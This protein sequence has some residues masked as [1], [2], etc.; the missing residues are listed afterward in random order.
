MSTIGE[1]DDVAGLVAYL[2][3]EEARFITGK[4]KFLDHRILLTLLTISGQT[5]RPRCQGAIVILSSL[6]IV[7]IGFYQ[8]GDA[9]RLIV[10][11]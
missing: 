5:V 8:R 4:F 3:K 2:A 6:L 9:F 7:P 1:P 11:I 10:Y